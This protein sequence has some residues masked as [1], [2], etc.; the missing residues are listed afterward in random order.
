MKFTTAARA[1]MKVCATACSTFRRKNER[2][3]DRLALT[4]LCK[5]PVIEDDEFRQCLT[6]ALAN[7][8]GEP[9]NLLLIDWQSR[10][11][12]LLWKHSNGGATTIKRPDRIAVFRCR[13]YLLENSATAVGS[14]ELEQ[15]S[16]LDRF[17]LFRH[18]RCLLGRE[19]TAI[20]SCGGCKMQGHDAGG[21]G[22]CGDG[23]CLRLCGSGAFYPPLQKCLRHSS[24]ALAEP[25]F[26]LITPGT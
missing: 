4:A 13:D 23:I 11:A 9:D 22:S 26:A 15:I 10:L 24:G 25:C 21:C 17:T 18:F 7:L 12:D 8:E 5:N 20:S 14:E 16:G 6:E 1:P 19:P 3:D 2:G